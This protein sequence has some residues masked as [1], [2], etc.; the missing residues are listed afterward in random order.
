MIK[1]ESINE[2]ATALSIAQGKIENA[3]KDTSNPFFKSKYA[4][5]SSVISVIKEPLHSNGLSII[6]TTEVI[7]ETLFLVTTLL[8]K[9]GQY[10]SAQLPVLAKDNSAQAMGSAITYSRRYGLSAML[11]VGSED[12][13]GNQ[14]TGNKVQQPTTSEAMKSYVAKQSAQPPNPMPN[15]SVQNKLEKL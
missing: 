14:A 11:S 5:L 15:Y 3:K 2:L 8:H 13:D 12:D 9:S 6:Q 4:D 1:S 7:G 10:I